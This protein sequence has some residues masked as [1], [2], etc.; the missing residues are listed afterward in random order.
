MIVDYKLRDSQRP[1]ER[2]VWLMSRKAE[3]CGYNV[4]LS[5]MRA[6]EEGEIKFWKGN[7]YRFCRHCAAYLPLESFY[8]NKRYVLGVGYICKD[9]AAAR[10]RI[11]RYARANFVSDVGMK[12]VPAGIS[13]NLSEGT[14]EIL[15]EVISKDEHSR[16]ETE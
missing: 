4:T 16:K 3:K 13:I 7:F 11:Q 2:Q 1:S 14:K 5:M 12:E 9:C 10:R 6:M 15:K 8:S